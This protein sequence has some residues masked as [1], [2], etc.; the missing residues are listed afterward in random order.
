MK[1]FLKTNCYDVQETMIIVGSCLKSMQPNAYKKLEE[2]SSNI[3]DVWII[4]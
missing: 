1:D 2:I 4:S 3:Y